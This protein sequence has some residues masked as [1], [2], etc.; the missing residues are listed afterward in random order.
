M[1]AKNNFL[2]NLQQESET[3]YPVFV[4]SHT[5][6][7]KIFDPNKCLEI[8]TVE[9]NIRIHKERTTLIEVLLQ[10]LEHPTKNTYLIT[11]EEFITAYSK[12]LVELNSLA[13]SQ[14]IDCKF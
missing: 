10:V 3:Q 8:D 11:Q 4:K 5:D 13:I 12:V 2:F 7:Y 1:D 9:L 14:H 6:F